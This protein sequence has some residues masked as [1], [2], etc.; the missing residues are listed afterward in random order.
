MR[1]NISFAVQYWGAG[2][3]WSERLA[4]WVAPMLPQLQLAATAAQLSAE[5]RSLRVAYTHAHAHAHTQERAHAHA[6]ARARAH[7]R[8]SST[9]TRVTCGAATRPTSW[10]RWARPTRCCSHQRRTS[11]ALTTGSPWGSAVAVSSS[12]CRMTRGHRRPRWAGC[13]TCDGS[14]AASRSSCDGRRRARSISPYALRSPYHLPTISL[15]TP[16]HLPTISLGGLDLAQRWAL[17]RE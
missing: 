6:R 4:G 7:G 17:L 16:Y 15:P 5:A 2:E 13:S 11:C 10:R 8:C 14:R 9:A 3:G 12:S 1:V